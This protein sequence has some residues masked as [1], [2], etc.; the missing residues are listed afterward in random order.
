MNIKELWS[1]GKM[2][3]VL[4]MAMLFVLLI[5]CCIWDIRQR[6]VP[7]RPVSLGLLL[8][9]GLLIL[10]LFRREL[11]IRQAGICLLPGILLLAAAL[12]GKGA[13]GSGDGLV[14]L[15]IG[16][17]LRPW[18]GMAAL[19]LGL[20]LIAVWSGVLLLAGRA[21]RKTR[22][23]FVPFSLAGGVLWM[24]TKAFW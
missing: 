11:D 13:V 19:L 8:T 16:G 23:P 1:G 6:A 4:P 17:I 3:E 12:L 10:R 24:A 2:A 15:V 5:L 7:L 9:G 22:L 18:D 21:G 20:L 14:W